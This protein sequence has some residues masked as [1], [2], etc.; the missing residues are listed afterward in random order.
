MR[1]D[2]DISYELEPYL[3]RWIKEYCRSDWVAVTGGV[4]NRVVLIR[5]YVNR[6]VEE[7]D[8]EVLSLL[9]GYVLGDFVW[10]EIN[11]G[12]S[13]CLSLNKHKLEMLDFWTFNK[14]MDT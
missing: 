10:E 2:E 9:S 1:S 12:S 6:E 14:L 4:R 7:D 11:N 5:V 3:S 13:E 8:I